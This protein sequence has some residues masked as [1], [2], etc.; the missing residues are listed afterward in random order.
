MKKRVECCGATLWDDEICAYCGKLYGTNRCGYCGSEAKKTM[1]KW[2]RRYVTFM[3]A[4]MI[5]FSAIT[6][7]YGI[8]KHDTYYMVMAVLLDRYHDYWVQVERRES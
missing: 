8:Y 7:F 3:Q 6:L 1:T 2:R 4:A 5:T